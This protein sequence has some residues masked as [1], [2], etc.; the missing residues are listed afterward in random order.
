MVGHV[1][2]DDG[3][4]GRVAGRGIGRMLRSHFSVG[5]EDEQQYGI[6]E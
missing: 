4:G 5:M 6:R 3:E 2:I 1:E